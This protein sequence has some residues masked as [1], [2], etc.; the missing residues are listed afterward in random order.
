MVFWTL[1]ATGND[2]W[3]F[4]QPIHCGGKCWKPWHSP[5][6]SYAHIS[7][8]QMLWERIKDWF[9]LWETSRRMTVVGQAGNRKIQGHLFHL[10]FHSNSPI[11]E[12]KRPNWSKDVQRAGKTGSDNSCS[13]HIIV[14]IPRHYKRYWKAADRTKRHYLHYV[15]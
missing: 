8:W 4:H 5:C 2:M 11:R 9:W 13:V 1:A 6:A 14:Y 15:E 7:L 10:T 3:R 12:T